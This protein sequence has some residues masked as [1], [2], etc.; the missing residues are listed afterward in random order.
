[1]HFSP[2]Q[3]RASGPAR[4]P[5]SGAVRVSRVRHEYA[6]GDRAQELQ[7]TGVGTDL[8]HQSFN[9]VDELDALLFVL[10]SFA[11]LLLKQP[12]TLGRLSRTAQESVR[13]FELGERLG[14]SK[15]HLLCHL[16]QHLCTLSLP[17][18]PFIF[19]LQQQCLREQHWISSGLGHGSQAAGLLSH[20]KHT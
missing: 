11:V 18:L 2:P 5:A 8:A 10:F 17:A 6:T 7:D 12:S 19:N 9:L 14:W 16:L 3:P 13:G 4:S 20:G 15:T 1:M